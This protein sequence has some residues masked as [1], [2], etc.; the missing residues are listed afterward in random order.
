MHIAMIAND[1]TFA[2]KLRREILEAFQAQGHRVTVIGQATA[3]AEDFRQAGF[4]VEDIQTPRRGTNPLQDVVLFWKLLRVLKKQKPDMV[5]TN[6]I[7]PN[8]YGGMACRILKIPYIANIT[9]LGTAVEIPSRMQQLTCRLYKMGVAGAKCV[10]FQNQENEDFFRERKMLNPKSK[11]CMLPGSGVNLQDHP[12][13]PYPEEEKIHFLFVARLLKEKGIEQYLAAAKAMKEKRRDV[14]FHICGG[15]DDEKY[16][17]ILRELEQQ[18]IVDY[19]GEQK[20]MQPFFMQAACLVHPSY[21]PEGMSN[22]L[23]EAAASGRPVIAADRSGCRETVD[24]GV[25]GYIVPIKDG[26]AVIGAIESFLR[27]S[28]EERRDM[29]LA[30]RKKMEKEFDRQLV[31]A[32]YI[33]A[34]I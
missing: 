18:D 21:Y 26:Q 29:G 10:F 12:V 6:N 11:V 33:R 16:L 27:L 32:E 1:T 25:S 28:W 14:E 17:D 9:G 24:D 4:A 15:C 8:V 7:K 22:V 2:Y 23:L 30:G 3:F 34:L 13:L 5:F 31:V 20:D 19:H